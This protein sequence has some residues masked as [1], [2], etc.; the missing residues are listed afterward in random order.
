[1]GRIRG[2]GSAG[3]LAEPGLLHT[4]ASAL[5]FLLD[6]VD[7]PLCR[8]GIVYSQKGIRKVRANMGA[9]PRGKGEK[10]PNTKEKKFTDLGKKLSS[11]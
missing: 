9:I 6:W 3:A 5:S 11:V 4:G 10:P 2:T 7:V 1:M 8:A